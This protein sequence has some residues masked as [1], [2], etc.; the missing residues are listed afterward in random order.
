[1]NGLVFYALQAI[2]SYFRIGHCADRLTIK[3]FFVITGFYVV[4]FPWMFINQT[5]LALDRVFFRFDHIEPKPLFIVGVPR[6]GTTFLHRLLAYDARQ[7]TT[8]PLWELIL[9]PSLIQKK[10]LRGLRRVDDRLGRPM[11]SLFK[12]VEQKLFETLDSMHPTSLWQPEEDYLALIPV[13]GCFLMCQPFP[14]AA[15]I[16]AL[17]DFDGQLNEQQKRKIIKYYRSIIQRH[18]HFRGEEKR[19]LSK[20]PSFTSMIGSLKREFPESSILACIRTPIKTVPSLLK[21]MESGGEIFNN[22][23]QHEFFRDPL[24]AMLHQM[25][26]KI[27]LESADN[28][29]GIVKY[30]HLTSD[31]AAAVTQIYRR[32]GWRMFEQFE[33]KLNNEAVQSKTYR[34]RHKYSL[35]QYDLDEAVILD[36]F[37]DVFHSFDFAAPL[38]T[39]SQQTTCE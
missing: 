35:E 29:D 11:M 17:A 20:N 31:P 39:T 14:S 22:N 38:T 32:L 34:S 18:L 5:A 36:R 25:Y 24:V 13:V 3:R 16:W 12:W 15:R 27:D 37:A 2:L 7:T 28:L 8:M 30:Q 23:L 19:Y 9:A 33:Q 4:F 26:L 6:S 1:M 10:L 21:A